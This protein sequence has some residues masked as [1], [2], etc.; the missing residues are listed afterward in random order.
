MNTAKEAKWKLQNI[1][2]ESD[3]IKANSRKTK[4]QIDLLEIK[5]AIFKMK[6]LKIGF[7]KGLDAIE[8]DNLY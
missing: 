1:N 6:H 5:N 2:K 7:K 8:E 3:R 4:N